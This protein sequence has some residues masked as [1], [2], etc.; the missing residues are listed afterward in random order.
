MKRT[1]LFLAAVILAVASCKETD[2]IE[3]N[4]GTIVVTPEEVVFDIEGGEQLLTLTLNS[5]TKEWKLTQ[6][7]GTDWCTPART[8]GKTSTSFK[9]NVQKNIG[10]QRSTTLEFTSPGC[11]PAIV[12]VSQSGIANKPVPAGA[13]Y[14]I[15][16]NDDGSVTLVFYDKDANGKSYDYA[17]VIGEFNDWAPS[18]EYMMN[19]DEAAGCWWYTMTDVKAYEEYMFQYYLGMFDQA[20]GRAFADPY[21]EVLYEQ[22]DRYISSSTYPNMPAFPAKTKGAISAFKVQKDVYSWE[23]EEYTIKDENDLVIYE[24]HFRDFTESGDINGAIQKLDYLQAL[25]VTAIELMPIQEFSGSDSWGYNPI[26]YFALEKSYGTRKMYKKFVDECHKRDMAVI[27]DVVYNHAHEDHAMAGLY[28]DWKSYIPTSDNPWFNV[29]APHPF[30]V[31]HDWNH[32]NTM[33]RDHIKRSLTYLIEEYKIDGFRFDLTKGFTNKQS[34]ESSASNYDASRVAI[35][36]EYGSHIKSVD[37][38]AVV[39]LEH[40]ADSEN[41]DLGNAGMKVWRNLNYEGRSAVGGGSGNFSGLLTESSVAFGTYVGFFESHDE[42]RLCYGAIQDN[43]ETVSWGI[44]GTLTGWGSEKDIV[45]TQDGPFYVAKGVTFTSDDMFKIRGNNSWNSDAHNLGGQVKGQKL[46]LDSEFTLSSGGGSQDMAAP[47]AGTYDVYMCPDVMKIWMMTP[48]KRP[49]EPQIEKEEPLT[50]AMRRA[51]ASAA[52]LL[53]VPGPKMIWQFGELGY[54]VSIEENGRTGRKP[55]HWEYYE[56]SARKALY[57]TYSVLLKFRRENPRF[58]DKDAKFEWTPSGAMKKITCSV[59][60]K[61]FHVVGNFG[62]SVATYSVPAGTWT[63]YINGGTVSGS[64]TLKEGEF[65]LL[66]K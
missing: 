40:F 42:E 52:F 34:N 46:P 25:G 58:F 3:E 13:E 51:G 27:V 38:N 15:N 5:S 4:K 49:A 43:S 11:D 62:K 14:G 10:E 9:I 57:D 61:T 22:Y 20:E 47:A 7:A 65:R 16:Y 19:R 17:Y 26:G 41:K 1:L 36:K 30:S 59:D 54:D 55:L 28:F 63:D 23:M 39:I 44:V 48:G 24:L 18:S 45:M 50:V 33:V 32:E 64:I 8:S 53:T 21:S 60:G 12:K 66:T 29:Y 2:P 6:S 56:I 37:P 35:L 31:F